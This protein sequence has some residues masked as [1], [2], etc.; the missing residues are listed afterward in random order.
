MARM[1]SDEKTDE[2]KRLIIQAS[3][4]I[5]VDEGFSGLTMAHIA[6]KLNIS[7]PAIY[8][9][10]KNKGSLIAAINDYVRREYLNHIRLIEQDKCL[11][12]IEKLEHIVSLA[13]DK[14]GHELQM[15]IVT[16]KLLLEY[17]TRDDEV[18]SALKSSYQEYAGY[19]SLVIEQGI[20]QGVFRKDI[21]PLNMA[22]FL[23]G[24][25]DGSLQQTVLHYGQDRID[26][27]MKQGKNFL[28]HVFKQ[29]L[30]KNNE[31]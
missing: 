25:L 24:A 9:Y 26:K 28:I 19:L 16:M 27:N 14:G 23:V 12:A 11:T 6:S 2:A 30:I 3:I 17:F 29:I 21:D 18:K 20:A 10:F 7:K 4:E 31:L 13:E 22:I 8:W 15:C 1:K 5:I